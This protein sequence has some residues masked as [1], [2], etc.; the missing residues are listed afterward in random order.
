MKKKSICIAGKNSIVIAG[1]SYV[2]ENYRNDYDIY[3]LGD[4]NDDYVDKWQPSYLKFAKENNL[5]IVDLEELYSLS[6]LSFIS[7][8]YFRLIDP[9]IFNTDQLFNI[10]FSLLPAYRIQK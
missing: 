8:E 4:K 7:L 5:K 2:L 3:A 1:L 10:H 9:K 6:D